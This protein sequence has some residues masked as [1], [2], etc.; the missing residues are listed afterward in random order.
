MCSLY[1]DIHEILKEYSPKSVA[2]GIRGIVLY[3][4][5]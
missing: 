2:R 1:E 3:S 4:M 5:K